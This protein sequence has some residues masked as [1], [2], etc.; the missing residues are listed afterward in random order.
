MKCPVC[1]S[2]NVKVKISIPTD[3]AIKRRRKCLDCGVSFSTVEILSK[4]SD[5][6]VKCF[7]GVMENETD[8]TRT[9]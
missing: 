3:F 5:E 6:L 4:V 2:H 1:K 8:E 7:L 9:R